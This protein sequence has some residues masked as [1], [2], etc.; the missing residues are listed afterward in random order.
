MLSQADPGGLELVV[1]SAG[2]G[3]G[4]VSLHL[5]SLCSTRR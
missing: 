3:E 1:S 2:A 5:P 4:N